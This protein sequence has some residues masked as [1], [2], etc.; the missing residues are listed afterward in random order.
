MA[1]IGSYAKSISLIMEQSRFEKISIK[2]VCYGMTDAL[3][4]FENTAQHNFDAKISSSPMV[5]WFMYIGKS[6]SLSLYIYICVYTYIFV[7]LICMLRH[8]EMHI[9][10]QRNQQIMV[11]SAEIELVTSGLGQHHTA[12]TTL[13]RHRQWWWQLC[14]DDLVTYTAISQRSFWVWA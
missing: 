10:P 5:W 3:I 7:G 6:L 12:L 9:N 8:R 14:F 2:I 1:I 13:R 4:L 11:D